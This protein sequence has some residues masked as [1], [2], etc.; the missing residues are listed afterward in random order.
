[1]TDL[2]LCTD[3]DRTLLPNG[4]LPES[5]AARDLFRRLAAHS[6]VTLVYITGRD[7]GLATEALATYELP[8]PAHL[9]V[10]VGTVIYSSRDGQWERWTAWDRKIRGDWGLSRAELQ[11][12]LEGMPGLALQEETR[13]SPTKLSY[14][15]SLTD[16]R[17]TILAAVR[18]RIASFGV[19]A[20]L[21]WSVDEAANCGLLDI[22][23]AQAT[24]LYALEFLLNLTGQDT[25]RVMYAGDSGNDLDILASPLPAVVVAN[26]SEELKNEARQAARNRGLEDKLYVARGGFLGLN[27]NYAGGILE[28]VAHFFPA[29]ASWLKGEA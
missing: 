4:V 28:G 19:L 16:N 2:L 13:Q 26:A 25:E 3:L 8:E 24:K 5:P 23:P 27:G 29:T 22:L 15:V 20:N 12:L 7:L 21:V 9:I 18:D 6:Q 11:R 14:F 10:D 1:M 17:E